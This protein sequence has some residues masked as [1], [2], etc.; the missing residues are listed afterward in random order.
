M[1]EKQA[2]DYEL[3]P[4]PEVSGL[5]REGRPRP[6]AEQMKEAARLAGERQAPSAPKRNAPDR[7]DRERGWQKAPPPHPSPCDG[8]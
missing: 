7:G 8:I 6:I 2:A 1:T 5:L 4:A 3:R